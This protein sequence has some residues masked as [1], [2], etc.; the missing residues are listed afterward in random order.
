MM[1]YDGGGGVAAVRNNRAMNASTEFR[2]LKWNPTWDSRA[3]IG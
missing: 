1:A 3:G 2:K